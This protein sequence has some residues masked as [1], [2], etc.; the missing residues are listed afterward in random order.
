M[1]YII[2][3]NIILAYIS[4]SLH[5]L[6]MKKIHLRTPYMSC[7]R[8]FFLLKH[9]RHERRWKGLKTGLYYLRTKAAADAIK[10]TVDVDTLK[11]LGWTSFLIVSMGRAVY[12]P[13]MVGF[14]GMNGLYTLRPIDPMGFFTFRFVMENISQL[15]VIR[16]SFF[17]KSGLKSRSGFACRFRPIEV[18]LKKTC[19]LSGSLSWW[20][21]S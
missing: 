16:N 17:M 6:I 1:I 15:F 10:F 20:F 7:F 8:F 14:Y 21:L 19:L 2:Y 3:I 12:L 5:V 11:R 13:Y 18:G 4:I 9:K